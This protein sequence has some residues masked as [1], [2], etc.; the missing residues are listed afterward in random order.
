MCDGQN[1]LQDIN[2]IKYLNN[3]INANKRFKSIRLKERQYFLNLDS[4]LVFCVLFLYCAI[5]IH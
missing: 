3:S 4:L 5:I 1:S 2:K